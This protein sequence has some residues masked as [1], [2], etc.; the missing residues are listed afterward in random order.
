MN[1]NM[2]KKII[3]IRKKELEKLLNKEVQV[4]Y[5]NY[6]VHV[7]GTENNGTGYCIVCD[8]Y[9]D[10]YNVLAMMIDGINAFKYCNDIR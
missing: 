7:P 1:A 10:M 9:D 2:E 8:S 5:E 3:N 6:I 4:I